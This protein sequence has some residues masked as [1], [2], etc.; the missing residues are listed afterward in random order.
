MFESFFG[1]TATPFGRDIGVDSLYRDHDRDET[2]ERLKYAA[3]KQL[4]AILTGESGSGK[5][6]L[7]R[8]FHAEVLPSNHLV[9]YI[10]DSKLTPRPFYK[11]ILEQL[12]FEAKFFRGD[13]KAQLHK[14][15]ETLKTSQN[16]VPVL[17]VDEAHL[18]K[19]E[20]LEEVR[21]LLNLNMDSSS[22]MALIL[23]GQSELS[24]QLRL[25]SY[26]AIRQRIDIRCQV[27]KLDKAGVI[28]YIKSHLDYAGCGRPL[29]SDSAL[30]EISS[31]AGG[32]PRLVNKACTASLIYAAQNQKSIIDERMVKLVIDS[33]LT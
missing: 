5:T 10:C 28:L 2:V 8:R 24:E 4:F 13:A 33:E 16:I 23:S 30:D 22:P 26:A 19:R 29:F 9:L 15:I 31:F 12:G 32:I 7:L 27:G 6:T 21:F 11:G 14:E 18:L 20:M 25:G 3:K 17:I 1:F